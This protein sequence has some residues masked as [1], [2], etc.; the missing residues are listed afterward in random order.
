MRK[1][2]FALIGA[3]LAGGVT[4]AMALG[5]WVS[6]V[7]GTPQPSA[8]TAR[9]DQRTADPGGLVARPDDRPG[10]DGSAARIAS[11]LTPQ[12]QAAA[13]L[14]A[15]VRDEAEDR[16][17]EIT[18]GWARMQ[19]TVARL[20]GRVAGLEQRLAANGTGTEPAPPERPV[21]EQDRRN[22]LLK[23][24]VA[25]DLAADIVWRESQY[26][27]DRL[28]LRDLAMREGW[29]ASD[30]YREE[31]GRLEDERPD[32]RAEIGDDA[33]DRFLFAAGDDNRVRITSVIPGSS[34]EMAG[35]GP[36]DLVE[37][38][39][40]ERVFTFSGL[41]DATSGGERGEL[42]PVEIRRADGALEQLWISRGPL[43]VRLDLARVDPET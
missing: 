9:V 5:A 39:D 30:R 3:F 17:R 38:Y 42:V 28:E 24:G 26:E 37:R 19:E 12:T 10:D 33:Y 25:A 36:G 41:R 18:A 22:A 8:D 4:G 20:E 14:T 11:S 35:L 32:L 15:A 1:Q 43:G 34:A 7:D 40:G 2:I 21:T 6:D 23:V 16:L 13:P 29:F 27:L 31:V